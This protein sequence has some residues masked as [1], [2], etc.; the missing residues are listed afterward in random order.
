ME[1]GDLNKSAEE[2]NEI[3]DNSLLKT[4]QTLT[5]EEQTQIQKNIGI[6]VLVGDINT[7]LDNINGEVI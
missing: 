2:I 3:L 4:E 6:D 1:Y 7:I 5:Q